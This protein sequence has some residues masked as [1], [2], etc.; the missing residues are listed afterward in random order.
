MY[1]YDEEHLIWI[2]ISS[3]KSLVKIMLTLAQANDISIKWRP[4]TLLD[5]KGDKQ[6]AFITIE[7][8]KG[9]E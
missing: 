1:F 2:S 6:N 8:L 3:F 7:N 5:V 4:F 9:S